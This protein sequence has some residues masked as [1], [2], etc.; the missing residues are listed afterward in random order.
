VNLEAVAAV[1]R[2]EKPDH[3]Q[4]A[5]R[6]IDSFSFMIRRLK[7]NEPSSSFILYLGNCHLKIIIHRKS[8]A[9]ISEKEI[10]M[11]I[12]SSHKKSSSKKT[13]ESN[14]RNPTKSS[15]DKRQGSSRKNQDD[16]EEEVSSKRT[17]R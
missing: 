5:A 1:N 13:M 17:R 14:E 8:P 15:L 7:H 9:N 12:K 3:L 2:K 11:G 4:A 6:E 16:S 10:Q